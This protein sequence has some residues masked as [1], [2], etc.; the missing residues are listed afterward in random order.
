MN[1]EHIAT[2]I[3]LAFAYS[4]GAFLMGITLGTLFGMIAILPTAALA[5]FGTLHTWRI[6]L[7]A[8][9][10]NIRNESRVEA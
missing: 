2:V 1:K 3:G 10:Q 8:A 5:Y 9:R 4:I 7:V 6:A